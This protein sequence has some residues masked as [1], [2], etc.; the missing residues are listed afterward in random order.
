MNR[1]LGW[2]RKPARACDV[3]IKPQHPAEPADPLKENLR[4]ILG[5]RIA[6]EA[7]RREIFEH[8]RP[9]SSSGADGLWN[10]EKT[11][12]PDSDTQFRVNRAATF[13]DLCGLLER[14]I[15]TPHIVRIRTENLPL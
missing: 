12:P 4:Q 14:A 3:C 6:I 11:D 7:A 1:I 2:M 5:Q 8:A 13:L 10:T 9:V 15:G